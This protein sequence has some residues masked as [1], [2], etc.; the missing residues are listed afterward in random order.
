M[1]KLYGV[2]L[3]G[4]VLIAASTVNAMPEQIGVVDFQK[5]GKAISFQTAMESLVKERLGNQNKAISDAAT[6]MRD[7]QNSLKD[8]T[9]SLTDAE[10][11]AKATEFAKTRDSLQSL[12]S[13]MASKLIAIRQ[14]VEKDIKDKLD[15]TL[16]SIATKHKIELVLT[17]SGA[18]FVA[19]KVDLTDELITELA[20]IYGRSDSSMA[21]STP[22]T[23]SFNRLTRTK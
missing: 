15:Q 9:K 14:S 21:S 7:L 10:K 18:A 20:K 8:D 22:S 11:T 3:A 17:T 16:G 23:T 12:Q 2:L 19:N 1:Q 13:E 5:V 6:K 4:A